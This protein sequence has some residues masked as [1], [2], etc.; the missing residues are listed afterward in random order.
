MLSV[1]PLAV[2]QNNNDFESRKQR[3]LWDQE[4]PRGPIGSMDGRIIILFLYR[5]LN[6]VD[7]SRLLLLQCCPWRGSVDEERAALYS[8][9]LHSS[10]ESNYWHVETED[11]FCCTSDWLIRVFWR[12]L[13]CFWCVCVCVC[14]FVWSHLF[15]YGCVVCV[16]VCVWPAPT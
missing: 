8:T 12:F 10:I 15:V 9:S 11:V 1:N 7:V 16:C 14:V 6:A 13:V 2:F 3:P 4:A 5:L